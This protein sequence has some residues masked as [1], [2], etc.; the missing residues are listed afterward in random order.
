M[1]I[2]CVG[3]LFH[4]R[5]STR[6]SFLGVFFSSFFIII[7]FIVSVSLYGF[8]LSLTT[9]AFVVHVL[10]QYFETI[11]PDDLELPT[12]VWLCKIQRTFPNYKFN[13][14]TTIG[15]EKF[16]S[17]T[18]RLLLRSHNCQLS[19]DPRQS[20]CSISWTLKTLWWYVFHP[21]IGVTFLVIL[22]FQ[23][24]SLPS[25][26]KVSQLFQVKGLSFDPQLSVTETFTFIDFLIH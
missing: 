13:H 17:R 21:T 22:L 7:I 24:T 20:I 12:Q 10:I 16:D 14:R 9:I 1:I 18:W 5:Q 2:Y 6:F 19:I 25:K 15:F 11:L 23:I 8:N 3:K 4:W 26:L